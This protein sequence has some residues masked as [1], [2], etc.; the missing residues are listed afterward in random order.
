MA[1]PARNAK[2]T[3]LPVRPEMSP[4]V[5]LIRSR[6]ACSLGHLLPSLV[7]VLPRTAV[8]NYHNLGK[9]T[10]MYSFTV[11]QPRSP[12]TRCRQ[13]GALICPMPF[14]WPLVLPAVLGMTLL[15]AS[16][17][18]S[19][20]ITWCP[21]CVLTSSLYIDTCLYINIYLYIKNFLKIYLREGE[22]EGGM[23]GKRILKQTPH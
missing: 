21:L 20:C 19:A 1:E 8:I 9:T 6:M 18:Q 12:K 15:K 22:Q 11:L 13:G 2:E 4:C 7:P 14:S 23:E 5:T 3:L 17:L 10:E 16:E